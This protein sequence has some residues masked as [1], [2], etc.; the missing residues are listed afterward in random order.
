MNTKLFCYS[1]TLIG[2]FIA[3]LALFCQWRGITFT[4]DDQGVMSDTIFKAIEAVG[5]AIALVGRI[6]ATQPLHILPTDD[7]DTPTSPNAGAPSLGML[8]MVGML[9]LG[10][11]GTSV[12]PGCSMFVEPTPMTPQ[13]QAIKE[14]RQA[15]VL[16]IVAVTTFNDLVATG[17]IDKQTAADLEIVRQ[18]AWDHLSAAK[19]AA[20]AGVPIDADAKLQLF[21]NDLNAINAI[22]LKLPYTPLPTLPSTAAPTT[23]PAT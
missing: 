14:V 7:D 22:L 5:L 1:K 16:Y 2:L 21:M 4:T 12:L 19:Q 11:L 17:K 20:E 10:I 15:T 9:A 8:L 6:V 18:R 3:S 13:D 23:Q